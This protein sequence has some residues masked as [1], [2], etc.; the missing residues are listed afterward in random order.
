[1]LSLALIFL[2]LL[3]L[4]RKIREFFFVLFFWVGTTILSETFAN[5]RRCALKPLESLKSHDPQLRD[6]DAIRVLE[7]GAG[8]GGNFQ[9]ITRTIKYTNVDPN[10]QFGSAFLR[11]LQKNPKVELEQWI[12]AYGEDMSELASSHFDVVMFTY[13]LCS[14]KNTRKVLEEAKRVMVKPARLWLSEY[15]LVT[16]A[17]E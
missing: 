2:P 13:L 14:V 6:K 11:Q 16:I 8:L 12:Q 5:S 3:L 15:A 4:S 10:V 7:I 9:H 17:V 1:M